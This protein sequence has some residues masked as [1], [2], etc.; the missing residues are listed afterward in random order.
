MDKS[1]IEK[2]LIV[3]SEEALRDV[4]VST[5]RDAGYQVSTDWRQGMKSVLDFGPDAVLL[6]ADPPQ[7]DCCDLLSEIKGIRAHSE[8]TRVDFGSWRFSGTDPRAGEWR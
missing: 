2:V 6:G 8:Y 3:E 7:L 1:N 5:L 4:V